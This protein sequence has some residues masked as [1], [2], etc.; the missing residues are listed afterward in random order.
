MSRLGSIWSKFVYFL[1][2]LGAVGERYLSNFHIFSVKQVSSLFNDEIISPIEFQKLSDYASATSYE[3][4]D[5]YFG[6]NELHGFRQRFT[7]SLMKPIVDS[8]Y[9]FIFDGQ[10]NL[11]QESS[12]WPSGHLLNARIQK[13]PKK[14]MEIDG[15][16]NLLPS[17]G[18]YHWLIED[19][20][21]F[22][23]NLSVPVDFEVGIYSGAER[24]VKNFVSE[25]FPN[26]K[27][28][29]K[30]FLPSELL[31]TTKTHDT[32]WPHP[33]DV[34]V[35]REFF[36]DHLSSESENKIY[37]SR[38]RSSRSP[39]W[40]LQIENLLEV[41]GWEILHAEDLDF[42]QQLHKI[43]KARVLCGVHGA[44]LAN[45]VWMNQKSTLI[46]LTPIGFR[47]CFSNLASVCGLEY[48]LISIEQSVYEIIN[49]IELYA[50]I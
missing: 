21:T 25:F 37:V 22:L 45:A 13:P 34:K 3:V 9:G 6:V 46:E 20:P 16:I 1:S 10:E 43:S 42:S 2:K 38:S 23:A 15:R 40:E 32:G 36:E 31:Q 41:K 19:L 27:L 49:E 7:I 5:P 24:Y 12:A 44:G 50:R 4:V 28:L 48:N 18:F 26:H 39:I 30:F 33:K 47:N 29:P 11:I 14:I 8:Q 17:S 35:L